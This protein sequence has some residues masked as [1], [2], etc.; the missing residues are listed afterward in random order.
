M[1]GLP[2]SWKR[3][4]S[5]RSYFLKSTESSIAS[6]IGAS[7]ALRRDPSSSASPLS[8]FSFSSF[9]FCAFSLS[10]W[11]CERVESTLPLS[12][13]A[14]PL[15]E[16]APPCADWSPAQLA[17]SATARNETTHLE[18]ISFT[19]TENDLAYSE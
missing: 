15:T 2:V 14:P 12:E 19:L 5:L 10:D 13:S 9:S 18:L 3:R 11:I 7:F 8:F 1:P 16:S 4:Q 6:L 17:P